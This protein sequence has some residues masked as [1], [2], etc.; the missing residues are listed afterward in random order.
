[1]THLVD[2]ESNQPDLGERTCEIDLSG[3]SFIDSSGVRALMRLVRSFGPRVTV[4]P[5]SDSVRR[6]LEIAGVREWLST[7]AA[8]RTEATSA[9]EPTTVGDAPR[10]G[11]TA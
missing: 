6:V 8:D 10:G 9:D 2:G 3:V 4:G 5:V 7:A 1:M 11:R